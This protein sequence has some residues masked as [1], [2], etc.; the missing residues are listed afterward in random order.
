MEDNFTS[1]QARMNGLFFHYFYRF[2]SRFTGEGQKINS[3]LQ[4]VCKL[5]VEKVEPRFQP[6]IFL[7]NFMAVAICNG[8]PAISGI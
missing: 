3:W 4:I 2:P 1:I 6:G 8:N 7:L 5:Q